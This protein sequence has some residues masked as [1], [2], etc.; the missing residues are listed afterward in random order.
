[1][2]VEDE[3]D[4]FSP[5][6][7]LRDICPNLMTSSDL[8]SLEIPEINW[9]IPKLLPAGL[10]LLAGEPKIGK[11]YFLLK[12]AKDITENGGKVFYFAGEDSSYLLQKR[13]KELDLD[14]GED[15]IVHCGRDSLLSEPSKFKGTI[16]QMLSIQRF[17]AIFLDN[18]EMVLP[19]K[20]KGSDDYA[21]YYKQ[22]PPWA[23]LASKHNC[24]I[25]MTHHTKK[26]RE[27]NPF[28][29]ILGSQAIMGCCDSVFVM[30]RSDQPNQFTLHATGKF[31][32]DLAL[33]LK[34][35]ECLFKF[36][37]SHYE[38]KLKKNS[39]QYMVYE[40]VRDHPDCFQ[41]QIAENA[42]IK[43]Q[44]V[45]RNIKILVA[46]GYVVGNNNIGFR[47]TRMLDDL[48]DSDDQ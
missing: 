14:V 37:G 12:L 30:E 24:T 47:I 23:M 29:T 2:I 28:K 40:Y 9:V 13:L 31:T 16:E 27:D 44:I 17:D 35:E 20:G 8:L 6:T 33:N 26:E 43:K 1:M 11:S 18:M 42:G 38:A 7:K 15:L 36:D 41:K 32:E 34:R 22:L 3:Y 25:L 48:D 19:A 21:Y 5:I 46:R 39:G 45:S 10:A 4:P